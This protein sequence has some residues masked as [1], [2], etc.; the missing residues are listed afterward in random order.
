MESMKEQKARDARIVRAALLDIEGKCQEILDAHVKESPFR[1]AIGDA[2]LPVQKARNLAWATLTY[3]VVDLQA[4]SRLRLFSFKDAPTNSGRPFTGDIYLPH[5]A[6]KGWGK[7]HGRYN[8]ALSESWHLPMEQFPGGP[9]I[10]F[11]QRVLE[12]NRKYEGVYLEVVTSEPSVPSSVEENVRGVRDRFDDVAL[13]WEAEWVAA[14]LAD[15]LIVGVLEGKAFL[16]DQYDV[17]KL[18]RYIVGEY[19]AR[20]D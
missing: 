2:I 12:H 13:V 8:V 20:Q 3:P 17:T 5:F 19:A 10:Y 9:R 7:S 18:E 11:D 14:P 16:V 6:W 15:P 1:Q 4:F